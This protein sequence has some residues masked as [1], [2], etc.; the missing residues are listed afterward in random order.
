M[1]EIKVRKLEPIIVKKIDELAKA[2]GMKREAFLRSHL[3]SLAIT[4]DLEEVEN[5]YAA[6]VN[7]MAERLEQANDV[8][9]R[10]TILEEKILEVISDLL[11]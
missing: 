3:T 11:Q 6:L 5:K 1:A 10:N 4:K 2:K 9:E 8:I 7:D